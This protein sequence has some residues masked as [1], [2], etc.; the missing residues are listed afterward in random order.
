MQSMNMMKME[1]QPE[2]KIITPMVN[3]FVTANL[4]TQ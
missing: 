4:S 3:L 2:S 1:I